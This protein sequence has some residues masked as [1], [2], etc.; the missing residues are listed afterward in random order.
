MLLLTLLY[1]LDIAPDGPASWLRGLSHH[2]LAPCFGTRDVSSLAG[3]EIFSGN[4]DP[5]MGPVPI[6]HREEFGSYDRQRILV[7]KTRYNGWRI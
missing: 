7:A 2:A 4:F 1:F 5:C 3:E 6:Q